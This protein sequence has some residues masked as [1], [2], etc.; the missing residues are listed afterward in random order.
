MND[1]KDRKEEYRKIKQN[2]LML[3]LQEI[4]KKMLSLFQIKTYIYQTEL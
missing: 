1:M 4:K 3:Q 2:T